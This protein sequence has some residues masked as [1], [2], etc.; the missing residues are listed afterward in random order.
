MRGTLDMADKTAADAMHPIAGTFM[1]EA[2][3]RAVD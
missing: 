3:P 1:L 2:R